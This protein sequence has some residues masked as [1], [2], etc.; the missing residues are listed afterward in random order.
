MGIDG[1]RPARLHRIAGRVRSDK[2]VYQLLEHSPLVEAWGEDDE[3]GEEDGEDFAAALE[4][5]AE[6]G[7]HIHCP[8]TDRLPDGRDAACRGRSG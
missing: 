7:L 5:A 4:P 6:A 2:A 3:G 1:K 8:I